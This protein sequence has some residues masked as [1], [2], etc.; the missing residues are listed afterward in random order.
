MLPA[1]RLAT[2]T[3]AEEQRRTLE[4]DGARRTYLLYLPP[5]YRAGRSVPLVVVFHAAGGR[6]S[7]ISRHTGFTR[8]AAEQGFVVA[9][10]D[11]IGGRWNDGRSP[12]GRDDVGFIRALL[13]TLGRELSLDPQ[14]IYA[15]GI[16]N[17]AMFA[18]RLGCEVPGV[19]AGIAAVAGAMPAAVA[20]RCTGQPGTSVIAIQGTADR[21]LPYAGGRVSGRGGEVLSATGTAAFWADTDHCAG[22]PVDT[23][24]ADSVSDGTRLRRRSYDGC[25]S[26]R[27]VVLYT[28]EGGGHT[29]PGGP[30][31]ASRVGLVSRELNA[32]R[33]IW[34]FFQ[35]HPQPGP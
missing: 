32:T 5:G 15:A 9:Y 33:A 35:R 16:S 24:V 12:G 20:E 30:P 31:A 3:S 18:Y 11:G 26:G 13:D 4:V 17:G 29:W 10:P 8:L 14:R 21:S 25:A 1:H 23:P 19:L 6:G 34:E 7:G 22:P 28:V 2:Q 27:S